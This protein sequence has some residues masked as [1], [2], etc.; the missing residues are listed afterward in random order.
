M[1]VVIESI[2]NQIVSDYCFKGWLGADNAGYKPTLLSLPGASIQQDKLKKER[3]M[4]IG[5]VSY[6][7]Y[8][9]NLYDIKKPLPLI[10]FKLEKAWIVTKREGLTYP[11]FVK[12]FL[13]IK[14]FTGAVFTSAKQW[15]LYPELGDWDGPYLC[16]EPFKNKILSEWRVFI[17]NGQVFSCSC[18]S[19]FSLHFPNVTKIVS[20]IEDFKNAP[21]AYSLDVAVVTN[22]N[23]LITDTVLVEFND[24]WAIGPYGCN[25]N[26]YFELL[27]D[28]WN[29]IISRKI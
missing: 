1:K 23:F 26:D 28:R 22:N 8:F 21:I 24:M 19:G 6:M 16:K 7:E 3:P 18:Y 10:D 14:K 29:E 13:D 2:N 20:Y 15:D 17:K 25:E 4:P 11:V 5:S 12:P 9:F 27:K